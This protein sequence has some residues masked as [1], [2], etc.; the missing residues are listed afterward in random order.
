MC[1]MLLWL[2]SIHFPQVLE[3]DDSKG[4]EIVKC[5]LLHQQIQPI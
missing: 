3:Q 2:W 4:Q 1:V 5:R